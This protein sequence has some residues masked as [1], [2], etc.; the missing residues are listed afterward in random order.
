MGAATVGATELNNEGCKVGSLEMMGLGLGACV[1]GADVGALTSR[2][3]AIT[4]AVI[5]VVVDIDRR[6][7]PASN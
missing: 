7:G 5:A 2:T 4:A 3:G 6:P 1:E